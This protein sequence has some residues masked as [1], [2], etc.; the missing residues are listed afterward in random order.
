MHQAETLC[1]QV[2]EAVRQKENS[3]K[4]EWLQTHIHLT[5]NE[6]CL[7]VC[8][9]VRMYVRTYVRMSFLIEISFQFIY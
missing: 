4:L 3:E 7:S 8:M 2:N 9:Y 5:L 1:S 6:V